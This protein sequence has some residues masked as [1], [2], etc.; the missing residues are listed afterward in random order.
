MAIPIHFPP[1]PLLKS[2]SLLPPQGAGKAVFSV[3]L[4]CCFSELSFPSLPVGICLPQR[5]TQGHGTT[6]SL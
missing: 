3:W 2:F 5:P 6:G 4:P 1:S